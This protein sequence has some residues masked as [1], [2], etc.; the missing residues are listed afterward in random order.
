MCRHAPSDK[1]EEDDLDEF[2]E[3]DA[4]DIID[5]NFDHASLNRTL[6]CVGLQEEDISAL[7]AVRLA[8]RFG[9][10]TRG[11][12]LQV[13][14]FATPIDVANLRMLLD[15]VHIRFHFRRV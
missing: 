4:V 14:A 11:V 9:M 15:A 12:A 8:R 1:K 2:N 7:S 10:M 3:D 13:E 5:S 6:V